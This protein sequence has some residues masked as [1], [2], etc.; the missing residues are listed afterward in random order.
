MTPGGALYLMTPGGAPSS[1]LFL[2]NIFI[3]QTSFTDGTT[4]GW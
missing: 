3:Q 2:F 1:K 4:F